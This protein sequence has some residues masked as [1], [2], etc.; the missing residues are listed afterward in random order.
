MKVQRTAQGREFMSQAASGKNLHL[1]CIVR[2][3]M[4]CSLPP[5]GRRVG[6]PWLMLAFIIFFLLWFFTLCSI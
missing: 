3:A 6:T 1:S 4:L 5:E 2:V